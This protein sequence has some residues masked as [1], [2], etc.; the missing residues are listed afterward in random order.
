MI[1]FCLLHRNSTALPPV[2]AM[3]IRIKAKWEKNNSE[4]GVTIH[5]IFFF[6]LYFRTFFSDCVSD[7]RYI[8][9]PNTD[10]LA[11]FQNVHVYAKVLSNVSFCLHFQYKLLVMN[12]FLFSFTHIF[13]NEVSFDIHISVSSFL[14]LFW[15]VRARA[16][17]TQRPRHD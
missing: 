12:F 15:L 7:N 14:P 17:L 13:V 3:H 2:T 5:L 1:S 10:S 11:D 6:L 16:T 4:H 8:P 9:I